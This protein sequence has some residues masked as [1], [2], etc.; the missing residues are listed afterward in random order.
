MLEKQAEEGRKILSKDYR[1]ENFK[2][3]IDNRRLQ[4]E[5]SSLIA[6]IAKLKNKFT[7]YEKAFTAKP[8]L[9]TSVLQLA[10]EI[11]RSEEL[12]RKAQAEFKH[13]LTQ[14]E[15]EEMEL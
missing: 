12:E 5:L 10:Y 9:L 6:E 13:R 11:E 8:A 2:L 3:Q 14:A 4:K 15:K 7:K 1:M